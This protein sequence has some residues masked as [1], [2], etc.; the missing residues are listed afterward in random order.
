M[1]TKTAVVLALGL[2]CGV[3]LACGLSSS[4]P[5]GTPPVVQLMP[6]LPGYRVI[7]GKTIAAYVATL[8]E[9]AA[10]LSGNPQMV[11]LI[12]RVDGVIACYQDL[13]AV[14][15][16]VFNDESFP[17]SSGAIAIVDQNRLTDPETLLRCT[18]GRL[19]PAA[20]E[21]TVKPCAHNY[22]LDKEGSE[23]H[24]VYIG[25][26]QEI[27]QTFCANLEGCTGH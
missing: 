10:L 11:F 15:V 22:T 13:G 5:T 7:E 6:D 3:T 23:L 25:T 4:Q 16:R 27:C 20:A 14:N 1:R 18:A 24:V 2:L 8:A 21:P 26:T 17:L 12:E 19:M 9:G